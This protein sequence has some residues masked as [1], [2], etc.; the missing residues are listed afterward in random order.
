LVPVFGSLAEKD[1]SA[2]HM[3]LCARLASSK[4]CTFDTVRSALS[5]LSSN[6]TA[7]LLAKVNHSV[8]GSVL[9][10]ALGRDDPGRERRLL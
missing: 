4:A 1:T 7:C 8:L 5:K 9:K 6:V 10:A 3:A 2:L